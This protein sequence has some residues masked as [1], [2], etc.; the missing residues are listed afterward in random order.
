ME[1]TGR[2]A[3][4]TMPKGETI[5]FKEQQILENSRR[6][7]TEEYLKKQMDAGGLSLTY[8]SDAVSGFTVAEDAKDHKTV[9]IVKQYLM[10]Y[11]GHADC[12]GYAVA[13]LKLRPDNQWETDYLYMQKQ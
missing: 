9:L 12:F 1:W 5:L 2:E 7:D 6:N 8:P 3:V 11:G 10:G 13:C 4:L